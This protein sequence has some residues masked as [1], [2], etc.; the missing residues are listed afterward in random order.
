MPGLEP[1][2]TVSAGCNHSPH[3]EAGAELAVF[4]FYFVIPTV[5]SIGM[6]MQTLH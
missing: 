2:I 4:S 1:E 6:A 5:T 3:V